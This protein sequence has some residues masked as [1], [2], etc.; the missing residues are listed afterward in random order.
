LGWDS[1][2]VLGFSFGGMVAQ[3][4]AINYPE[5][6]ERLVLAS[7]TSGGEGGQSY[8]LHQLSDF[9]LQERVE[10][11]MCLGD[12]RLDDDWQ[13]ANPSLFTTMTDQILEGLKIGADEPG[14]A[15]GDFR[16]LQARSQHN[17]YDRL[18]SLDLPVLVCGGRYDGV[19]EP[20][21]VIAMQQQ[22]S[23]SQ[24][25]FFE[26]GHLFFKQDRQSIQI[27]SDFLLEQD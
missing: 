26:G 22:I 16:Q 6:V 8:P 10:R 12:T 23:G 14:R 27:M 25:K 15:V 13:A 20:S 9:S 5:R 3:E 24:I 21:A 2:A 17:T 7:T 11:V 19:A 4:L 1:C 18:P